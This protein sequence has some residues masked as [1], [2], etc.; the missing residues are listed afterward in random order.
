M[1]NR[2]NSYKAICV[3]LGIIAALLLCGV[4]L[5]AAYV[6]KF[7]PLSPISELF[8]ADANVIWSAIDVIATAAVGVVTVVISHRLAN[9]QEKQA[10]MEKEQH[11]LNTEPHILV[12]AIEIKSVD[13]ELTADG[14]RIKTI[15]GI[16][17]PYYSNILEN[18]DLAD[19]V[20]ITIT[21]VNTSEAFARV[22]FNE[23]KFKEYNGKAIAE[24]N[25]STVG[26]HENHIMIA[27]G[28]SGR[29]G[30]LISKELIEKI[31]NTEF[32]ISTYLDNNFNDCFKDIQKYHIV[33][34]C[35]EKVSFMVCDMKEN[36][37]EK[38][39]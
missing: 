24:Y 9:L 29:L 35:E 1:K 38:I 11:R 8:Q 13:Y 12:D 23:A 25:I 22:R 3:W 6:Y 26:I 17:Y 31:E 4:I 32:F 34:I 21:I 14:S 37:F 2:K 33:G 7:D 15:K 39:E 18:D 19:T 16:D 36:S 28:A 5:F 20:M 30:L 10:L 27:K